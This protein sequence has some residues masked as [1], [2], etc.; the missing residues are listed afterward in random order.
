MTIRPAQPADIPA[1]AA[2]LSELNSVEGY[3]QQADADEIGRALFSP[4]REVKLSALVAESGEAVIGVV[5]FYPGYDTLS[6]VEGYHLADIVVTQACRRRGVA[7]A[8]VKALAAMALSEGKEWVSLTVLKKNDAARGFYQ[9][10]GMSEVAV[11]FFAMG[12]MALNRLS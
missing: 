10:L 9:S 5:L 3:A 7:R 1:I 2:L 8:L 12:K 11:D 6:G 4:M